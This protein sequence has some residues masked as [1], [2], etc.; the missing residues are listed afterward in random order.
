MTKFW[1]G[2]NTCTE[3]THAQRST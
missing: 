1:I 2:Q 3:G